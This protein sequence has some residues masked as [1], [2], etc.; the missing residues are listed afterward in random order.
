MLRGS[1]DALDDA[2]ALFDP[3]D[4]L[5][6]C[7][8]RYRDLYPLSAD[9]MVIGNAFGLIIRAGAGCGHRPGR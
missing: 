1:I 5:L 4:R 8:Q 7:N 9:M 6:L 2:C 3:V